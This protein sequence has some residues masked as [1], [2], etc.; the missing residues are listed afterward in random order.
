MYLWSACT[1]GL[2]SNRC[3]RG[4]PARL[5]IVHVV[6][7]C[8]GARRRV[9]ADFFDAAAETVVLMVDA[10]LAGI[11]ANDCTGAAAGDGYCGED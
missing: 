3:Q 5:P 6:V 8:D 7:V 10:Q 4:V 2:P 11:G 1:G 9:D